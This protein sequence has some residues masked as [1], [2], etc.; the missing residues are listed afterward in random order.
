MG[1]HFGI[2]Y[3]EMVIYHI[4]MVNLHIDMGYLLTL[5][6]TSGQLYHVSEMGVRI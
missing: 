4:D 5:V 3:I 1:Y 6:L 2:R